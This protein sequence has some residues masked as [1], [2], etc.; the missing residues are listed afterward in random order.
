MAMAD[1]RWQ[2]IPPSA[3]A[4]AKYTPP[5]VSLHAAP[6]V[7]VQSRSHLHAALSASA[8]Y[9]HIIDSPGLLCSPLATTTR[10]HRRSVTCDVRLQPVRNKQR[11]KVKGVEVDQGYLGNYRPGLTL[12]SEALSMTSWR[13]VLPV[14]SPAI[15]VSDIN[16]NSVVVAGI[17]VISIETNI[18]N[19][20]IQGQPVSGDIAVAF[21]NLT[22]QVEDAVEKTKKEVEELAIEKKKE[23]Q[24]ML[25]QQAKKT[26]EALWNTK[27]EV[28]K[29]AVGA[30]LDA[31][32]TAIDG[33]DKECATAESTADGAVKETTAAT[34]EAGA[35][36]DAAADVVS[37]AK[38][39]VAGALGGVE[40]Q[41]HGAVDGAVKQGCTLLW[42]TTS[43]PPTASV[44]TVPSNRHVAGPDLGPVTCPFTSYKAFVSVIP[45][46]V[47]RQV[48]QVVDAK[49]KEADHFLDEKR[50]EVVKQVKEA[51]SKA[52][53]QA[54][55]GIGSVL[56]KAKG[57]LNCKYISI[58]LFVH[59]GK[60]CGNPSLH[61][62]PKRPLNYFRS[63]RMGMFGDRSRLLSKSHKERYHKL[64]HSCHRGR[65]GPVLF[66][67]YA[68]KALNIKGTPL[69][70][71]VVHH[72]KLDLSINPFYPII[73][74][75]SDYLRGTTQ[76][77]S[78][79]TER[80]KTGDKINTSTSCGIWKVIWNK[81]K[82]QEG[83]SKVQ[84]P[85]AFVMTFIN[86][87]TTG[88]ECGDQVRF[89]RSVPLQELCS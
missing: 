31:K 86:F 65:R 80:W 42:R 4:P 25:E 63:D 53:G 56:G 5:P 76:Y 37:G 28:E 21:K 22:S 43:C 67:V 44:D 89:V 3:E 49:L 24:S 11:R 17:E 66:H 39:A 71:T 60:K 81:D 26:G 55:E 57:L 40:G 35:T 48:E 47:A 1:K 7:P 50:D 12:D 68:L 58:R 88:S 23:A 85:S 46:R 20:V 79:T 77:M 14:G 36:V 78:H 33:F 41:I 38:G 34:T 19:R 84:A 82:G 10:D 9:Q 32:K 72:S 15:F 18:D 52:S 27:A 59:L 2:R 8:V 74:T 54:E 29:S 64:Y 6:A 61:L 73:R 30:A 16:H 83:K 87:K 75:F 45:T 70:P 51:T 69:S 62:I 13:R